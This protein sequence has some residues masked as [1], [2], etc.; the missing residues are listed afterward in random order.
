MQ[1]AG[2]KPEDIQEIEDLSRLP[3]LSKDD[4]IAIQ[5]AEPPFGGMLACDIS[6]LRRIYQSPGPIYEPEGMW[7]II[8]E[9]DKAWKLAVSRQGELVFNAFSYHMTPAGAMFEEGL[10]KVG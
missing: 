5:A 6:N 9:P 7:P 8:G 1:A 10:R 3:I 2:L 4:L